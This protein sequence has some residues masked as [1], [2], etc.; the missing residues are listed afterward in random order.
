MKKLE[1]KIAIIT[2][3]AG[4]IGKGIATAYVKEGATVAII[5][6]NAEAGNQT[7]KEL[8][9]YSP[10]SIFIQANL[11]E[12][13]KL[14][15]IVK[16]VADKFGKIDILVNNAHAS[17]MNSIADTTQKDFDL[18][19]GTGFYPTFYFMQAALPYLKETQGNII[20]FA[21]GAGINGDVNQVSYAVAKEAI[22]AATRVAANEFGPFGINVNIIAPIAK[23]PGLVQWAEENP[24]YYQG[25]LS[26]IPMRRLGELEGDI[27]RVAVFLASEDS[28]YITGQTIMVDGGSIKLR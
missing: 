19:F 14:T 3:A 15:D 28:A 5:D 27:G 20:N 26:K 9:A 23:S 1:G 18:S 8:Q 4:G 13:D 17:R 21:S 10:E 12:H 2:G 25:M 7:I 6:L 16:S 24:E 22:R 11:S